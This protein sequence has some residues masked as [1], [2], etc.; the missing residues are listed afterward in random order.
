M[1]PKKGLET[2]IWYV[3]KYNQFFGFLINGDMYIVKK[4]KIVY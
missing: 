2:G 3:N 4:T 1:E